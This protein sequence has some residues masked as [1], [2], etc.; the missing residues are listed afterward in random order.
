MDMVPTAVYRLDRSGGWY[1]L[2]RAELVTRTL[3]KDVW[4]EQRG[5]NLQLR[6]SSTEPIV[7]PLVARVKKKTT[8]ILA[9]ES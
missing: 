6:V 5:V 8:T 9:P 4:R 2:L 3:A 1:Q 7:L